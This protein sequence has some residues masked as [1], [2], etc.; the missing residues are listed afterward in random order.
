M[1]AASS[2][3][4]FVWPSV[5][6]RRHEEH[7]VRNHT[8]ANKSLRGLR[9]FVAKHVYTASMISGR[10]LAAILLFCTAPPLSA[11]RGGRDDP[12]PVI[13]S[14]VQ[15]MYANDV[16]AYNKLTLPHPLRSRLT[17]GGRVN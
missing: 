6:P 5:L 2:M 11:Q 1:A 4:G 8:H 3:R 16:E 13:R 15:A 12:G 10:K 7:E 9:V 17:S 14:L